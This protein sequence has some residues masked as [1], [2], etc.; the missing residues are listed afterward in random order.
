MKLKS[1]LQMEGQY[2]IDRKIGEGAF[3]TVFLARDKKHRQV[4]IKLIKASASL[5]EKLLLKK[6][7]QLITRS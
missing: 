6:P 5:V 1:V 2:T 7:S 4:A 3:G